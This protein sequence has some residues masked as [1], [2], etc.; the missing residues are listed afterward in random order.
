M[1]ASDRRARQC[2]LCQTCTWSWDVPSSDLITFLL[3]PPF[4]ISILARPSPLLFPGPCMRGA[5]QP[6]CFKIGPG[7]FTLLILETSLADPPCTCPPCSVPCTLLH[8]LAMPCFQDCFLQNIPPVFPA[9]L[10]LLTCKFFHLD[11]LVFTCQ[12]E[13]LS[14]FMSLIFPGRQRPL[15][16]MLMIVLK[17]C[18]M[19]TPVTGE[20]QGLSMGS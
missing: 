17:A 1:P 10:M 13:S 15:H 20:S 11:L 8:L 2:K 16:I 5:Q 14:Q 4:S 19:S 9:S 18:P 12:V 7:I 3:H 6:I